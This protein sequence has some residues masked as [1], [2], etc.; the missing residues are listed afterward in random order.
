[1]KWKQILVL[2]VSVT[3]GILLVNY[4]TGNASVVLAL[5]VFVTSLLAGSLMS[6]IQ[7]I[8]KESE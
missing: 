6:Y 1:M 2:S 8:R 4:F 3:A 7:S 5:G